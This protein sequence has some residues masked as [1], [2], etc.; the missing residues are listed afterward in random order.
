[1]VFWVVALEENKL[2]EL[3]CYQADHIHPVTTPEMRTEWENTTLR[4]T[5]IDN[6]E[7]TDVHFTHIGLTP[8]INC[9]DICHSGWDYFFG[10]AFN[11]YLHKPN[12]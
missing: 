2:V 7:N 6:G 4:F 8:N 3:L 9:Y 5:I 11:A 10:S 1:M 12:S